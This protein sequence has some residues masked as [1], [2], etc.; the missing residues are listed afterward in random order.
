MVV[1]RAWLKITESQSIN[2]TG[3][4]RR[5]VTSDLVL[6]SGAY[7]VE[8]PTLLGA[9]KSL[10]DAREIIRAFVAEHG[11]TG[12]HYGSIQIEELKESLRGDDGFMRNRTSGYKLTQTLQIESTNLTTVLELDRETPKLV[13]R[14]LWFAASS[15]Q[16]IYTKAGEAKVEML[17]E[18][19][20]DARARAEQ[21]ASQ[22]DARVAQLRSAKMGVFQITPEYSND[23]SWGGMYDT[24]SLNKVITAVVNA[25]FSMK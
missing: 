14:G 13:E 6:W 16:F 3:S 4:A 8:A 1:T 11:I 17:A 22:G 5:A 9:Q 21:I 25:T 18:A 2:V 24:S 20:K 19:T 7:V 10:G 12:E 15:P 23:T